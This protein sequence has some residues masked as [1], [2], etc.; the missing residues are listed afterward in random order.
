MQIIVKIKMKTLF[1]TT[2]VCHGRKRH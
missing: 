2:N 1:V